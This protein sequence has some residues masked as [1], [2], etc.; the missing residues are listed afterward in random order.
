MKAVQASSPKSI[1]TLFFTKSMVTQKPNHA[2]PC[3]YDLTEVDLCLFWGCPNTESQ[4]N[5]IYRQKKMQMLT[6]DVISSIQGL[7]EV[8]LCH[9]GSCWLFLAFKSQHHNCL[10]ETLSSWTRVTRNGHLGAEVTLS[11][12]DMAVEHASKVSNKHS[13]KIFIIVGTHILE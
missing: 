13:W 5:W 10:H 3:H 4:T 12:D 11:F 1:W 7:K 2:N 6:I 8:G 9:R